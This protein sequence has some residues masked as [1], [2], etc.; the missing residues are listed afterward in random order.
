[1]K[2]LLIRGDSDP[3]PELREIV[4]AG[5]TA[6]DEIST[7]ELSTFVSRQGFG[8]DRIAIALFRKHGKD[9]ERWSPSLRSR[10]W[11]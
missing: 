1:M 11:P 8:V 5:S 6:V 3:P 9:P 7:K 2:T 10:L 4:R